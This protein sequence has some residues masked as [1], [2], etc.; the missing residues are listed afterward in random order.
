[1]HLSYTVVD[2][3]RAGSVLQQEIR[4]IERKL[5]QAGL[6][7]PDIPRINQEPLADTNGHPPRPTDH[8][9]D[10]SPGQSPSRSVSPSR[11]GS[12][13]AAASPSRTPSLDMAK[14]FF[15][16]ATRVARMLSGT[17][18]MVTPMTAGAV[19]SEA[20]DYSEVR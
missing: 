19:R 20:E 13:A 16:K 17:D 5:Q 10:C 15:L 9:P 12:T 3:A 6:L 11:Q 8:S 18:G 7:S 4:V 14:Y 2:A 1:M